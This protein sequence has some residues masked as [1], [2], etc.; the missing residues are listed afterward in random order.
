MRDAAIYKILFLF[1]VLIFS[2]RVG[3]SQGPSLQV[4]I[5]SSHKVQKYSRPKFIYS[6]NLVSKDPVRVIA[7]F[8]IQTKIR[9]ISDE[10][11]E[12]W[13]MGCS[14]SSTW[15]SDHPRIGIGIESCR[16]NAPISRILKPGETY[17][18]DLGLDFLEGETT[19]PLTFRLGFQSLSGRSGWKEKKDPVWSHPVTVEIE[20]EIAH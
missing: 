15:I 11:Q 5:Y 9:N 13:I 8:R 19:G 3:Y 4:E 10:D 7:Q 18:R 12:F 20:A 16:R 1:S 17:D 14:Y 2:A 6:E